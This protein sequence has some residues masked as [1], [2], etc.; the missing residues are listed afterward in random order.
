MQKKRTVFQSHLF[1]KAKLLYFSPTCSENMLPKDH[2]VEIIQH[3]SSPVSRCAL[4][5]QRKA[6]EELACGCHGP[7]TLTVQ[8]VFGIVIPVFREDEQKYGCPKENVS[9]S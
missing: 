4:R 2:H 1:T 8:L 5:G 9:C 7:Q 3:R 6:T